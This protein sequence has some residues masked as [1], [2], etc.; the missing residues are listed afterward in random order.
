MKKAIFTALSLFLPLL[1]LCQY[2][3][4]IEEQEPGR[5]LNAL[6]SG[7]IQITNLAT[8]VCYIKL[9]TDENEW[10]NKSIRPRRGILATIRISEPYLYVDL[11]EKE[12]GQLLC[13]RYRLKPKRRYFVEYSDNEGRV[14]LR[15]SR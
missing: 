11:C 7:T 12:N 15:K 3:E 5:V 1:S 8:D 13:D 10:K 4:D 9:S 14:V 6:P 2:I